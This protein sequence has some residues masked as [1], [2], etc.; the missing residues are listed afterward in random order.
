MSQS[1]V[2]VSD[3]PV[4]TVINGRHGRWTLLGTPRFSHPS[5]LDASACYRATAM[6]EGKGGSRVVVLTFAASGVA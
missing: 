4:G 5:T 6:W 2:N 3:L 1:T